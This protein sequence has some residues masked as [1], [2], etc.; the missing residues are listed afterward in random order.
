MPPDA[1][2]HPR[3]TPPPPPPNAPVATYPVRFGAARVAVPRGSWTVQSAD[4]MLRI[5]IDNG[6]AVIELHVL[7]RVPAA[8][9][10]RIA[11]VVASRRDTADVSIA[12]VIAHAQHDKDGLAFRGSARVHGRPI[13]LLAVALD[14]MGGHAILALGMYDPGLAPA[15]RADLVAVLASLR[16]A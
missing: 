13:E 5:S 15:S 6:R 11:R 16:A 10:V 12:A 9:P 3:R 7:A 1:S 8:D 14:G 2:A 4:A